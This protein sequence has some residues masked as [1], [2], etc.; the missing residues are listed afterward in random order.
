MGTHNEP[1]PEP[2]SALRLLLAKE[3]GDKPTFTQLEQKAVDRWLDAIVNARFT[4]LLAKLDS[5]TYQQIADINNETLNKHLTYV[6][7][8]RPPRSKLLNAIEIIRGLHLKISHLAYSG[9]INGAGN[10]DPGA[11]GKGDCEKRRTADTIKEEREIVELEIAKRKLEKAEHDLA[12][13][14]RQYISREEFS[15]KMS[16]LVGK[17]KT[18]N[19]GL[20]KK[21][22]PLAGK[23]LLDCCQ[24]IEEDLQAANDSETA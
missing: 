19:V 18:L 22:G 21:H 16:W 9:E 17:L 3:T 2:E 13:N 20:T 10:G 5:A 1:D 6:G 7:V 14:R 23:M 4:E 24:S 15:K 12:M 8:I 11:K